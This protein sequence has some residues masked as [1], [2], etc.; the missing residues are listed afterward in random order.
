MSIVPKN[1][2][3][4]NQYTLGGEF[5]EKNTSKLYQGYYCIVKTKY[6]TEK[7]YLSTSVE[8][9]KIPE[10]TPTTSSFN[11]NFPDNRFGERFFA[12]KLNFTP[13]LI[14]E[15][16]KESY[17]KLLLDP[18]YQTITIKGT[19]IFSGSKILDQ[20]DKQMPGLKSFLV[21]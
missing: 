2:I 15:V 12:K 3:I 20:A 7:T 4:E 16:N 1:I 6:Y 9:V 11:S 10:K 13:I 5:L 14:R 19:E 21:G 18:F 17:S 8:L